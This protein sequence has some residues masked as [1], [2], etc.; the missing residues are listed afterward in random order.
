MQLLG[1]L[2]MI[3]AL[4]NGV[5]ARGASEDAVRLRHVLP[6][7]PQTECPDRSHRNFRHEDR[8]RSSIP[9]TSATK[10]VSGTTQ[11]QLSGCPKSARRNLMTSLLISRTWR[12]IDANP[13]YQPTAKRQSRENRPMID[14]DRRS[15]FKKFCL[16]GA[17]LASSEASLPQRT[18]A[19]APPAVN[20]ICLRV[21][22]LEVGG[23][24]S[25]MKRSPPASGGST[26]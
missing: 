13:G 18:A 10:R 1:V 9:S 17:V 11:C 7:V 4:F 20:G 6:H 23:E 25:R 12:L 19:S 26:P 8:E 22:H 3:L 15:F 14:K 16:A 24:F 2:R 21:P 5:L